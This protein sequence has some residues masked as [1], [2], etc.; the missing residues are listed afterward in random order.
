MSFA[1]II[2]FA[3]LKVNNGVLYGNLKV[4]STA[5]IFPR[6][7]HTRNGVYGYHGRH[8][9]TSATESGM[10]GPCLFCFLSL[11]MTKVLFFLILLTKYCRRSLKVE[12]HSLKVEI[13]VIL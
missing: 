4:T 12:M 13:L 5:V 10:Q 6:L 9:P 11:R 3:S 7:Y 2:R 8:Q 1:K